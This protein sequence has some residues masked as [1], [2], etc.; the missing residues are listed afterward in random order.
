MSITEQLRSLLPA[1][2]AGAVTGTVAKVTGL[3]TGGLATIGTLPGISPALEFVAA[4]GRFWLALTTIWTRYVDTSLSTATET[5]ILA[6]VAA[7]VVA[8]KVHDKYL[9]YKDAD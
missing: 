6:G 7:L 2:L 8:A 4:D 5:A 1:G 3:V 9:D